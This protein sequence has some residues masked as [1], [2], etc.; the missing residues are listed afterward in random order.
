MRVSAELVLGRTCGRNDAFGSES[1]TLNRVKGLETLLCRRRQISLGLQIVG[2]TRI[3]RH[4]H[5]I[6]SHRLEWNGGECPVE[7]G[8][9]TGRRTGERQS[10][11]QRKAGR[12]LLVE[13]EP[14]GCSWP[15]QSVRSHTATRCL[16]REKMRQAVQGIRH[17]IAR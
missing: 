7:K 13:C 17:C 9:W 2:I 10:R 5:R 1:D 8:V 3:V 15:R 4:T 6:Q 11:P 14:P 16:V 12:Q